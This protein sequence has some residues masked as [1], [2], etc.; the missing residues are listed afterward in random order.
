MKTTWPVSIAA[1]FIFLFLANPAQV[2]AQVKINEFSSENGADWVELYSSEEVDI[3][4][5]ILRDNA[6]TKVATIPNGIKIGPN[7]NQFYIIEAGNRLNKDGDVIILYKQDDS[8][9]VN[10]ISYGSQEDL[11]APEAGQTA[12]RLP[13]GSDKI[14][15][16][17]APTKGQ[18]NLV[19]EAPCPS[20]SPSP[21]SSASPAVNPSPEAQASPSPAPLASKS[22]IPS[23]KASASPSPEPEPEPTPEE[24]IIEEN[25]QVLGASDSA[26]PTNPY[27]V[28]FVLIGLGLA[29]IGGSIWGI[30]KHGKVAKS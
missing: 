28:A 18:A 9:Q 10:Q 11:C 5:W 23:P 24:K 15:R 14:T 26:K 13:D 22:P 17:A 7:T 21:T 27:R 12:G 30:M 3:S 25:S 29:L 1:C 19:A 6:T 16:F 2:L 20:P 8:T 4:G